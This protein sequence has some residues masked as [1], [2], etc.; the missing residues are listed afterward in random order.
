[1]KHPIQPI[2]KDEKSVFRFKMN[3]IVRF[4]INT[5]PNVDMNILAEMQFTKD[6]R[7]QFLQLIGSSFYGYCDMNDSD[8]DVIKRVD[9]LLAKS[10]KDAFDCGETGKK[11]RIKTLEAS[12][13][14][15]QK[16]IDEMSKQ[17]ASLEQKPF[18]H[19]FWKS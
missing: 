5:H 19:D 8:P 2:I 6:D 1:M 7:Q 18:G 3:A 4:L 15:L 10:S 9:K 14:E 16:K 13:L 12:V 11:A 17:I